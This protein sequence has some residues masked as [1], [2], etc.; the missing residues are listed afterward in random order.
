MRKHR[1]ARSANGSGRN[2]ARTPPG[3]KDAGDMVLDAPPREPN[4]RETAQEA[5]HQVMTKDAARTLLDDVDPLQP[6]PGAAR[7]DDDLM[8]QPV[9]RS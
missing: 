9:Q 6:A 5:V 4:P 1:P 2:A 7:G 3:L 8:S